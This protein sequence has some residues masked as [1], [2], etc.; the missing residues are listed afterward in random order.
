MPMKVFSP[1]CYKSE[2]QHSVRPLGFCGNLSLTTVCVP[3]LTTMM[4]LSSQNAFI[5]FSGILKDSSLESP[6]FSNLVI[7]CSKHVNFRASF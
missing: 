6:L 1:C 2:E 5:V 3:V 7:T 4:S